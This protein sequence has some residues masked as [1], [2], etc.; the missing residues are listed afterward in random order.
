MK[1]KQ[2]E[3]LLFIERLLCAQHCVIIIPNPPSYAARKC[4]FHD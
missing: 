2:N 3:E 1:Y 4:N